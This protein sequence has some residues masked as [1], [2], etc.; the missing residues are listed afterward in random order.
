MRLF[1]WNVIVSL[2][3]FLSFRHFYVS[4]KHFFLFFELISKTMFYL[5]Q[6]TVQQ[7]T[8][9][10]R[11][12][13]SFAAFMPET[14]LSFCF[15]PSVYIGCLWIVIRQFWQTAVYGNK[16]CMNFKYCGNKSILASHTAEYGT[17]NW[18][19]TACVLTERCNYTNYHQ[20]L[21][22]FFNSSVVLYV[23]WTVQEVWR[24]NFVIGSRYFSC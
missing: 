20:W 18:P 14:R 8:W 21:L 11:L 12:F 6:S 15:F 24:Q 7:N 13:N 4:L 17:L 16:T 3:G 19:I 1:P 5:S 2:N 23:I 22:Q 10:V 9:L